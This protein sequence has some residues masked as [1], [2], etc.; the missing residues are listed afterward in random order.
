MSY[1]KQTQAFSWTGRFIIDVKQTDTGLTLMISNN[2]TTQDDKKFE[3]ME[4]PS[5]KS[6][7]LLNR[8]KGR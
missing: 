8:C 2:S 5:Y 7:T 1:E 3:I 4:C 6:A